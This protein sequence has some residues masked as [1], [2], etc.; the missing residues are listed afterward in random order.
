[1]YA[2]SKGFKTRI[3]SGSKEIFL[4]YTSSLKLN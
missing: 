2:S 4:F 1:M 3:E